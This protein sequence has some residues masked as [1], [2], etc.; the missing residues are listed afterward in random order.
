MLQL[1][2]FPLC[3]NQAEISV[4]I[5]IARLHFKAYFASTEAGN[6]PFQQRAFMV[7]KSSHQIQ[8]F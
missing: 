6:V 7:L 1:A 5:Y 4:Y 2:K 8:V 3:K